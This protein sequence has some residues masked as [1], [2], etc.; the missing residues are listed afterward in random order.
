MIGGFL[1]DGLVAVP[2]ASRPDDMAVRSIAIDTPTRAT[3]SVCE[4]DDVVL[5][6]AATGDVVDGDVVVRETLA[7]LTY[8]D[9]SWRL[10]E[11]TFMTESEGTSC[12]P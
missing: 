12:V 1:A 3:V 7:A 4:V 2:P 8:V 5:V 9:G 6:D 10:A 11:R